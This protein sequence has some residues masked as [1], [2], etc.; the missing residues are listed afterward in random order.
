M[1]I[2][3]DG[4]QRRDFV[5]VE[6]IAEANILAMSS[7]KVGNGEII[8]IGS[9]NSYSVWD[10][11]KLILDI[12]TDTDPKD[13]LTVKKCFMAPERRGEIKES[14]ADISKAKKMLGWEPKTELKKGI[15][16]L[17]KFYGIT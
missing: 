10:T 14:L 7:L 9:G 4:Y 8:N 3:P 6:D 17:F 11:A 16:K 1:P 5:W 13:L 12:S 2:V 15:E